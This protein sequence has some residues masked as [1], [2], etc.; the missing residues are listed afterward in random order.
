M[1]VTLRN[2]DQ[3]SSLVDIIELKWLLA[4]EGLRVHVERL[5]SDP[6]Y[7]LECLDKAD[8]SPRDAVRVAAARLRIRLGLGT[9]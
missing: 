9:A 6:V 1:N 4:N 7:A 8:A 3:T 5:Q 2:E